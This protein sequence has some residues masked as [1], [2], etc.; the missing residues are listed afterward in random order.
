MTQAERDQQLAQKA[1][2]HGAQ[3][4]LRIVREARR[5]KLPI[6]LG[7][8][9]VEQ[10]SGFRNVFGH[11]PTIFAGAGT[12]TQAKYKAYKAKRGSQGKGGMQGVGPCQLTF[13]TKQD[14]A[15]EMGGC[16]KPM[17]NIRVAFEDLA[18]L[19]GDYGEA[20]G[21]GVY[22]AGAGGWDR[23]FGHEYSRQVRDRAAKWHRRLA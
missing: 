2:R 12:V 21:I 15:D 7:F 17:Y 4:S 9:L 6:S 14:R 1:K 16:W 8:A 11:D 19:I 13:W 3:Y 23:G 10:E 5:A 20:K 22:N 18:D